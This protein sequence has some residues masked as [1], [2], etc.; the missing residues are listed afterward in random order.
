M[1]ILFLIGGLLVS[2]AAAD[3]R[4][5]ASSKA[6]AEDLVLQF[7]RS[8]Y[9]PQQLEVAEKIIEL[10]DPSVLP[11]L[12]GYLTMEDRHARGNAALVYARLGDDRGFQI[13]KDMLTDNADR[14]NVGGWIN[15]GGEYIPELQIR[16]DHYYAVCLLGITRDPRA[17]PILASLLDDPAVNYRVPAALS[18]TGNVSAIPPLLKALNSPEA[19]VRLFSILALVR[20][21][22]HEAIPKLQEMLA[23]DARS[24]AGKYGTVGET[25]QDA[26]TMIKAGKT[27]PDNY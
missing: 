2:L 17:V 23:D 12:A 21:K 9:F 22:A 5:E 10:H 26:I 25:A 18:D 7:K 13:I 11:E 27:Y 8:V 6:T 4:A 3:A 16:D 19:S 20:M 14:P 24:N 1:K 15:G